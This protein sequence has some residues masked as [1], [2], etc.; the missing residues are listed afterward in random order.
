MLLAMNR[1]L[2]RTEGYLA[3]AFAAALVIGP[4][5]AEAQDAGGTPPAAPMTPQSPLLAP[6]ATTRETPPPA[7]AATQTPPAAQTEHKRRL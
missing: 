4:D 6:P 3:F 1:R 2:R 7:P 5:L